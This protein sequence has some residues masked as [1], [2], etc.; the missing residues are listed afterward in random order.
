MEKLNGKWDIVVHTYMGDQSAFHELSVE[1]NVLTGKVT[2]K[3]NGAQAVIQD[4]K[5]DGNKFSYNFEIQI[6]VGKLKMMLEGEYLEN[7]TIKGTSSNAMGQF[8]FDGKK[9]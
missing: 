6:P 9:A 7:E 8:E 1:G 3:G 2:D 4:G 5:V